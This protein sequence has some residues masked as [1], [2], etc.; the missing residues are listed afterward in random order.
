MPEK[1]L[2]FIDGK[3]SWASGAKELK[4]LN[5]ADQRDVIGLF[6][7]SPAAEVDRAVK[8]ARK[9]YPSWKLCPAPERAKIIRRAGEIMARRKAEL[10]ALVTRECGKPLAEGLGDVQE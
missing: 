3:W 7:D 5:P 1:A 8:A 6:P 10:G 2:N 9:A 4:S